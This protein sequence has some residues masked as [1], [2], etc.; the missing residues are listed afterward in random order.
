MHFGLTNWRSSHGAGVRA[1]TYKPL[2]TSSKTNKQRSR[3]G[4]H[5][6][7]RVPVSSHY[8]RLVDGTSVTV[9]GISNLSLS[10][11]SVPTLN[12]DLIRWR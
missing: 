11:L 2:W 7:S 3:E 6:D 8:D 9:R 10:Q 5:D 4:S 1:G 12:L